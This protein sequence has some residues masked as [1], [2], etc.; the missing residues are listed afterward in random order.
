MNGLQ[1]FR[2]HFMVNMNLQEKL[3]NSKTK[4]QGILEGNTITVA[5]LYVL[6]FIFLMINEL[7]CNRSNLRMPSI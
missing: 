3:L 4:L 2:I 1:T 7:T 6:L 5:S